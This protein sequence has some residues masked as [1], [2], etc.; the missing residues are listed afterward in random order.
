MLRQGALREAHERGD[1]AALLAR[2]RA[3]SEQPM[4]LTLVR[5]SLNPQP[6]CRLTACSRWAGSLWRRAWLGRGGLWG[7]RAQCSNPS[8]LSVRLASSAFT[9]MAAA[10]E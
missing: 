2:A 9:C 5:T 1:L 4:D 7:G 3:L 8:S 10:A 6:F